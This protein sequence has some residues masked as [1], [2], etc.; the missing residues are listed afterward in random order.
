MMGESMPLW[1]LKQNPNSSSS[2]RN[3]KSCNSK[4]C[5]SSKSKIAL[6]I[7]TK[8]S[9]CKSSSLKSL[10]NLGLSSGSKYSNAYYLSLN[11]QRKTSEHEQLVAKEAEESAKRQL[12]VSASL[13]IKK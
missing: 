7:D 12:K 9:L 1:I 3:I 13:K 4:S 6:S 5:Q 10:S 8:T 2:S 11:E